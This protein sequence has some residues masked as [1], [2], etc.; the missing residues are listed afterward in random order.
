[1]SGAGFYV[2]MPSLKCQFLQTLLVSV[3]RLMYVMFLILS[4]CLSL[5]LVYLTNNE[6]FLQL[7]DDFLSCLGVALSPGNLAVALV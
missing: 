7:P 1:M 3:A 4:L 5:P 2:R 6:N